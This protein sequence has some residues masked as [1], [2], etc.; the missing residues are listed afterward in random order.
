MSVLIFLDQ[1]DGIVRKASIEAACYGAKI[2]AQT[3]TVAEAIVFGTVT[4]DLSSFG[5]YG[6]SKVHTV[7]D[8]S[9]NQMDAQVFTN[10]LAQAAIATNA[11][12]IVFSNNLVGKAVIKMLIL[13][14]VSRMKIYGHKYKVKL[15]FFKFFKSCCSA[16]TVLSWLW[17]SIKITFSTI[18]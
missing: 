2:A 5:K 11:T 9:L 7:S 3:G 16:E 18:S 13:L 6:I 15:S 1:S 17:L 10:V 12:V 4:E 14:Y 8:A